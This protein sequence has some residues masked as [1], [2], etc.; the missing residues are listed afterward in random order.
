MSGGEPVT[1]QQESILS[2]FDLWRWCDAHQLATSGASDKDGLTFSRVSTDTRSITSGDLFVALVGERFDAHDF[3][4][5]AWESGAKAAIVSRSRDALNA[6]LPAEMLLI[7]ADDTLV[8]LQSL[9]AAL[10]QEKI[11]ERGVTSISLTGSNGKT[12]SK[13]LLRALFSVRH[14][15]V[16]ATHGNF[17]NHIGVPLTICSIPMSAE[18]VILEM[19]ASKR[20]DID[21]LTAIAPAMA[22]LITSIGHAHL[23]GMGGLDGV[24][25]TKRE[26]FHGHDAATLAVV[27]RHERDNLIEQDFGGVVKTFCQGC[28]DADFMAHIVS[29]EADGTLVEVRRAGEASV[30]FKLPLLG[31]H[32]VSN[33]AGCLAIAAG[34]GEAIDEAW[35]GKAM[36]RLHI[37]GGR[38][39][40]VEIAGYRILNDSYNA[41]PTSMMASFEAF[42]SWSAHQRG[43]RDALIAVIGEMAEVGDEA[44]NWHEQ[45]ACRMVEMERQDPRQHLTALICVGRYAAGMKQAASRIESNVE[46][47]ACEDLEEVARWLTKHERGVIFLKASRS[48]RLERLMEIIQDG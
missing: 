32:H 8:A 2:N 17:N 1:Q 11:V 5:T 43:E 15:H 31:A 22:R 25:L 46:V 42:L 47:V 37:P 4:L 35:L 12:T 36:K 40:V 30:R 20:G 14:D 3:L 6:E 13:E 41:N 28:Q 26:I 18:V 45:I 38:S 44:K 48:A 33:V 10:W 7:H 16:H 9:A 19:G 34:L 27:P 29:E 21:E 23:E 39:E 24:R